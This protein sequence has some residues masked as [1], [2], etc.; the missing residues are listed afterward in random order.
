MKPNVVGML[1]IS[2]LLCMNMGALWDIEFPSEANHTFYRTSNVPANGTGPDNGS[3]YLIMR[4]GEAMLQ[5]TPVGIDSEGNWD[6]ILMCP[7]GG[8]ALGDAILECN[9]EDFVHAWI[10]VTFT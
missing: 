2:L 7:Q 10:T 4:K 5:A 6:D 1:L 8:W 3:F 9:Y